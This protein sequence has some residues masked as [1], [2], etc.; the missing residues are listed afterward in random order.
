MRVVSLSVAL[1]PT[2]VTPSTRRSG[3]FERHQDR[4]GVVGPG[5]YVQ[6]YSH[7]WRSPPDGPVGAAATII[8]VPRKEQPCPY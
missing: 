8:A 5:V 2:V 7:L 1:P 4:Q 3:A 6:Y